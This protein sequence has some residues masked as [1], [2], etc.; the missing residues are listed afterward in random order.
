MASIQKRKNKNGSIVWRVFI[1]RKGF[2]QICTHFKTEDEAISFVNLIE[3]AIEEAKA[4]DM[5]K[6]WLAIIMDD[7]NK[8][9]RRKNNK[10]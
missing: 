10:V 7:Y 9:G 8:D 6:K 4:M 1:R 3:N 5:K 2:K